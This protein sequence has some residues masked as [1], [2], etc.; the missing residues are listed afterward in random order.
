MF[1]EE[2]YKPIFNGIPAFS[3]KKWLNR[4]TSSIIQVRLNHP[5]RGD[6][7]TQPTFN[8]RVLLEAENVQ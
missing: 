4:A 6:F 5:I 7:E 1:T 8:E 3:V 2:I